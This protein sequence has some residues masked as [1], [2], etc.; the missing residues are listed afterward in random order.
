MCG[1]DG[2]GRQEDALAT[3]GCGVAFHEARRGHH[4]H[5]TIRATDELTIAVGGQQRHVEDIGILQPNAQQVACLR[6]HI[7][8]GAFA[9]RAAEQSACGNYV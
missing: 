3:V 2:V 5:E 1:V 7:G 8:P 9:M 6:L 4:L